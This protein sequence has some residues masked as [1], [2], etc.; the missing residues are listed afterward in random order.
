MDLT[1]TVTATVRSALTIE[2][3]GKL[4]DAGVSESTIA[5]Q[6][7]DNSSNKQV[8][9]VGDVRGYAK[10]YKDAKSAVVLTKRQTEALLKDQEL[11]VS[12]QLS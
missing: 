1:K 12:V 9:T 5:Q 11:N 7:T 10:L 6:L 4:L 3:V 8:Y 2:R